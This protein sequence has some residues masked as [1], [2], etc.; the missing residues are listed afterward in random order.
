MDIQKMI[1]SYISW[2]KSEITVEQ[3][4]EYYEITTPFLD[5]AN[6]YIQFYIK[7]EG[8]QVFFTDDGATIANLNMCGIQIRGQRQKYLEQIL[9]QYGLK[10]KNGELTMTA[11]ITDFAQKKH[12]YIQA[13]LRIDDMISLSRSRVASVFIDDVLEF[14][15][16]REFVYSKDIQFTGKSG[17]LHTYD[18][19]IPHSKVKPERC[20]QAINSPSK[21]NMENILFSW[22]D[23]KATRTEDSQLIVLLNDQIPI[24]KGV[25]DGFNNYNVKMIEWSK[26]NDPNNISILQ[27]A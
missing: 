4:G 12:I 13:L 27:Y 5:N 10:N 18:F 16:Q 23:T 11:S 3:Y 9:R 17:F 21:S 25:A 24:P 7:Q 6:D 2:L 19:L 20:C 22:I 8:D 14:F 26:R 15:N 1:D